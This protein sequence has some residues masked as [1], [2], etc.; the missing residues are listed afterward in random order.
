MDGLL[1]TNGLAGLPEMYEG[2][3]HNTDAGSLRSGNSTPSLVFISQSLT[4]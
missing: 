1:A 4:Y 2:P 3:P